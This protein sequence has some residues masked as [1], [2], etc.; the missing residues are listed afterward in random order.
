MQPTGFPCKPGTPAPPTQTM[1][2]NGSRRSTATTLAALASAAAVGAAW[3][4]AGARRDRAREGWQERDRG[5]APRAALGRGGGRRVA[6][7]RR[8]PRPRGA[9]DAPHAGGP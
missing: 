3:L 2:D 5:D 6:G 8:P 1:S 7:R 4:A 9:P